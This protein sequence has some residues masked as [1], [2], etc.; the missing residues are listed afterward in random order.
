MFYSSP[1]FSLRSISGQSQVVMNI[2]F[3]ASTLSFPD[4]TGTLKDEVFPPQ[5]LTLFQSFSET[6]RSIL[7]FFAYL[8]QQQCL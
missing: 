4:L 1:S 8:D 6:Q 7:T 2:I 3:R 5:P